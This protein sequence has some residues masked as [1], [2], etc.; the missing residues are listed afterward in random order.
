M[1]PTADMPRP[2]KHAT[3]LK[4]K[5]AKKAPKTSR[6]EY[7]RA[8]KL[9]IFGRRICTLVFTLLSVAALRAVARTT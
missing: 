2:G 9:A 3:G 1:K 5:R 4:K 6:E 8:M 7:N